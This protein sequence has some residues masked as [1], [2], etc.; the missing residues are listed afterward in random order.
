MPVGVPNFTHI[1][2]NASLV[3]IR[4]FQQDGHMAMSNPKGQVNYEQTR[5]AIRPAEGATMKLIAPEVGGFKASDGTLHP[6]DEKLDGGPSVLFDAVVILTGDNGVAKLL[7][8]PAARDFVADAFAHHKFI[9]YTASAMPLLQKAGVPEKPDEGLVLLKTAGDCEPFV[10]RCR[11]LR[12][13][14]RG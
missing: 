4:N 14:E 9:G 7:G 5:G 13:W 2:I 6:A 3:S 10:S 11:R 1:P 12:F 8:R